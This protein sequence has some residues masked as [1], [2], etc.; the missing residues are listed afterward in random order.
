MANLCDKCHKRPALMFRRI[1]KYQGKKKSRTVRITSDPDHT[2]CR[3]CHNTEA[4]RLNQ[5]RIATGRSRK[6]QV[7]AMYP[8]VPVYVRWNLVPDGLHSR[9]W[10]KRE[11]V[12]IPADA[13]PDGVKGGGQMMGRPRIY[14]LFSEA[15]YGKPTGNAEHA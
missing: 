1:T 11:G 4:E 9:T 7:Q 10:W 2:L 5:E 8:G 15:K 6:A 3:Q 12:I 13:K 14:E